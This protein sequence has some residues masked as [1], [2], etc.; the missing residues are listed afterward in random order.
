MEEGAVVLMVTGTLSA[1]SRPAA[2]QYSWNT[3]VEVVFAQ[4]WDERLVP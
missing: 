4:N 2:F 3:S 1:W